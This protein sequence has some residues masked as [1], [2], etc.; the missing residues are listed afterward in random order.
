MARML[1]ASAAL[2]PAAASFYQAQAIRSEMEDNIS[3]VKIELMQ[4]VNTMMEKMQAEV[5]RRAD[6]M[7]RTLVQMLKD[8]P[9]T[10][11]NKTVP[12]VETDTILGHRTR[13]PAN[14]G[15]QQP[16]RAAQPSWAAVTST[17]TQ[18]T[19]NWTTV[20]SGKKKVKKHPLDQRRILLVRNVQNHTCDPRDIMFEVNK[21]LAH[22]KA[23]VTVR[24]IKMGYTEKGNLTGVI[25]ENALAED[26][27]VHAQAVMA[28][29]QKLDPEVVYMDKTEKWCKLRVHGGALDRYMTEGGLEQARREI[30]LM[31][32]KQLP[33][34]P[35]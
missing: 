24:L 19:S 12:A 25:G 10:E 14:R 32:G 17:G 15:K 16:M 1:Q 35:R 33:Y 31:P 4:L 23:R 20:T 27:F 11:N 9:A 5:D 30:E 29:V 13:V 26:L 21:A 18:K 28:A 8:A 6:A 22:A 3:E 34:A 2:M 7:L